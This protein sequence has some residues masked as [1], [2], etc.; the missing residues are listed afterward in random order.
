[1]KHE[2]LTVLTVPHTWLLVI[3]LMLPYITDFATELLSGEIFQNLFSVNNLQNL[4][5]EAMNGCQAQGDS[6]ETVVIKD[7]PL[8]IEVNTNQTNIREISR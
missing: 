5:I 3:F 7:E 4:L 6:S 2:Q 8:D 1:M